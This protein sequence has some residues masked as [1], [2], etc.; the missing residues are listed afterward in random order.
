MNDINYDKHIAIKPGDKIHLILY[1]D[2]A[3]KQESIEELRNK[4]H[5]LWCIGKIINLHTDDSFY[6]L[7]NTGAVG[8][9]LKP[10]WKDYIM[11][12]AIKYMKEIYTIPENFENQED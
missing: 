9:Y 5:L 12:N 3:S 10:N 4:P 11:R 1:Y 6:V 8:R 7:L 2:H